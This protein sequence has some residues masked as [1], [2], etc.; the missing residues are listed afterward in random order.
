[1]YGGSD[2]LNWGYWTPATTTLREACENLVDKL[3]ADN[4]LRVE[5]SFHFHTRDQFFREAYRV[6]KPGGWLAHCGILFTNSAVA[7]RVMHRWPNY[8]EDPGAFRERLAAAGFR[9]FR[10]S[11]SLK[12]AEVAGVTMCR[13][14][15]ARSDRRVG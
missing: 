14:G 4:V 10:C 6:L 5:A 3:L 7:R 8:L 9:T 2:F 13:D 11:T 1:M 15:P 12:S